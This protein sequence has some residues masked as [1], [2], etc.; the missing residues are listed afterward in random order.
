LKKCPRCGGKVERLLTAPAIQ[1]KGAGWYVT[2]YAGKKSGGEAE[3]S[4][5]PTVETKEAAGKDAEG[6]SSQSAGKETTSKEAKE[7][8]PVKKK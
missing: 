1:F 6:A 4:E 8:K 5:K 3:K 7:R 2:D